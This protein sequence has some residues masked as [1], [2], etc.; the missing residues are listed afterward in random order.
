[1]ISR[2]LGDDPACGGRVGTATIAA[3]ARL[4]DTAPLVSF[5][6]AETI[7]RRLHD[8]WLKMNDG[9]APMSADN[10]GWA[11]VVQFVVREARAIIHETGIEEGNP[12]G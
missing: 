6:Q 11:D 7:G 4:V 5:D 12:L 2:L 9:T 10:L 8:H 3:I 1:M